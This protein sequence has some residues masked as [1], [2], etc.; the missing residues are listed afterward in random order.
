MF[1]PFG[2]KVQK[3]CVTKILL[4]VIF[5]FLFLVPLNGPT[6]ADIP[7]PFLLAFKLLLKVE[8]SKEDRM[9]IAKGLA[10]ACGKM[11][12]KIPELSPREN[13]WVESEINAGRIEEVYSSVEF[14]KREAKLTFYFC[15][16]FAKKIEWLDK[17]NEPTDTLL[18]SNLLGQI[19]DHNLLSHLQNL[20]KSNVAKIDDD[21]VSVVKMFPII[22]HGI[23]NRI[24]IPGIRH[25]P[26]KPTD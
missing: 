23:V 16:N 20:K 6:N 17:G 1:F 9:T 14:A 8:V 7:T 21:D 19:L 2:A 12:K 18:W 25:M 24:L 4:P 13:D 3:P 15:Y 11:D 22:S 10:S 5:V 26:K